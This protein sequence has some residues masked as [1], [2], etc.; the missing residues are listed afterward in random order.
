M[1][2]EES[3]YEQLIQERPLKELLKMVENINASHISPKYRKYL[4]D[5]IFLSALGFIKEIERIIDN[6]EPLKRFLEEGNGARK[7]FEK[8]NSLRHCGKNYLKIYEEETKT[9][10][11]HCQD[12][13][14][15]FLAYFGM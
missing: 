1:R 2:M 14:N 13:S 12:C 10:I 5:S 11:Y 15:N 6:N 7:I 8:S 4:D 9:V 3:F